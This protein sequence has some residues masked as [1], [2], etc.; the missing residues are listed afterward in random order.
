MRTKHKPPIMRAQIAPFSAG[1]SLKLQVGKALPVLAVIIMNPVYGR[2]GYRLFG[3]KKE[4]GGI[5]E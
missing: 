5:G 4:Y 1:N 3:R 2:V